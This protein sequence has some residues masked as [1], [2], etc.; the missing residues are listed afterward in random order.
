MEMENKELTDKEMSM[1]IFVEKSNDNYFFVEK[2]NIGHLIFKTKLLWHIGD[3][4][5]FKKIVDTYKGINVCFV[6][7]NGELEIKIED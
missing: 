4:I 3:L 7:S 5:L 6:N 2:N 1:Q